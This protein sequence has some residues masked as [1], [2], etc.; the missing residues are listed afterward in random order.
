MSLAK[1]IWITI[2]IFE[3][4]L[5]GRFEFASKAVQLSEK[6]RALKL[7]KAR[8]TSASC[9]GGYRSRSRS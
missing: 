7:R 6:K 4:A 9:V 1:T 3:S 2:G 5:R 8:V